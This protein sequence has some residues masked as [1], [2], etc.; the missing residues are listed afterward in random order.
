MVNYAVEDFV[1]ATGSLETVA[2]ALETQ[3]ETI[4][5]TKTIRLLEVQ[6]VGNETFKGII[7]WDT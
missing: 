3:L 5:N 4:D 7:I 6:K 2:A 1:T